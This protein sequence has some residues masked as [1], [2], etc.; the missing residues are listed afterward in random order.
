MLRMLVGLLLAVGLSAG[1]TVA[2]DAAARNGVLL[3]AYRTHAHV[4]YSKLA[5]F[6]GIVDDLTSFLKSS[7]VPIVN[8]LI[9]KSV[10]TEET[11]STDTLV[12]YLRPIGARR[13][14]L[15]AVDRPLTAKLKLILRCYDPDGKLLWEETVR[16]NA[17]REETAVAQATEEL[18][19]RLGYR[20]QAL[21]ANEPHN[22]SPFTAAPP[23]AVA[24]P[25]APVSP[26]TK[27]RVF[28][29]S[30]SRGSNQTA[31]RDQSMEMSKDFEEV[32]P[33]VRITITQQAADYTVSLN[34][35]EYGFMRDNQFQ[36]ADRNGD[37]I[38]KTKEGGSIRGG[39]KKLCDLIA[40]NWSENK[41]QT[42]AVE[43]PAP[44]APAVAAQPADAALTTELTLI[45][46]P[47]GAD[48]E[49]DGAF[50]GST[51]STIA[52]ANGDHT[53]RVSKKGYRLYEKKL[54]TSGGSVSLRV[55]LDVT[56]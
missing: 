33:G 55:E 31:D 22:S 13:L 39:V 32:C 6:T 26:E 3:F 30:Q 37:L 53:V 14:L 20:L 7:G 48:I 38:S 46:T 50:V 25:A 17:F 49:L 8:D 5:V 47:N 36:V 18:H 40:A 29:Q 4:R 28:L 1:Q 56:Q 10:L 16:D 35:T 15:L 43:T 45:S 42:P 52:V 19:E 24:Q 23:A 21:R 41:G 44:A 27:P 51:P 2:P 9:H 54:R 34:H 12:T 11:T